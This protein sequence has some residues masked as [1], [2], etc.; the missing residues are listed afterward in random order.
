MRMRFRFVVPLI[1]VL[2][3]V[4][5]ACGGEDEVSAPESPTE[6]VAP[7]TSSPREATSVTSENPDQE[8]P[9]ISDEEALANKPIPDQP[10]PTQPPNPPS[11][12][13]ADGDGYYSKAELEEAIRARFPEYEW[14]EKY[15]LTPDN[16]I[17]NS[18]IPEDA[19][20]EAP[21]EYAIIGRYHTCSWE[22]TLLEAARESDQELIDESLYQLVDLGQNKN[23]LSRDEEGKAFMREMY[24]SAVLGDPAD[25]QNWVNNNCDF[26]MSYFTDTEPGSSMPASFLSRQV[27]AEGH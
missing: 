21:G 19:T 12:F 17:V 20:F 8:E 27:R 22:V 25:L 6:T 10:G 3:L 14:P 16:I 18:H 24:N 11:S 13:D 5:V 7:D 15:N 2:A 9:E 1:V 23:P 4:L 26:A